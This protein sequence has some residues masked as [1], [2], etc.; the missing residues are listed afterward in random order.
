MTT[1]R[2]HATPM[3]VPWWSAGPV[4]LYTGDAHDVLAAMPDASADCIVTSPP[5]WGK[6]RYHTGT[7]QAGRPDCDHQAGPDPNTRRPHDTV[8][9][10]TCGAVWTDRQ[11]GL[12]S[13]LDEYIDHLVAVFAQARRVLHPTGTMWLNLGDTYASGETGRRDAATRYPTLDAT[14][15]TRTS[16]RIRQA[17]GIGRKNLIGV[18]WRVAL[19]LQS[20][21]WIL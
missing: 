17:S 21:N 2:D 15:P 1:N 10:P 4:T 14:Q 5:Y 12:E 11:Y 7:W 13:T 20:D 3:L 9:C 18:P 6:R 16:Q 19:A 8:I